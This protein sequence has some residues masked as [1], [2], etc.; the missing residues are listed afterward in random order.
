MILRVVENNGE[1]EIIKHCSLDD[2]VKLLLQHGKLVVLDDFK[3]NGCIKLLH[4]LCGALNKCGISVLY[5]SRKQHKLI[6][7]LHGCARKPC[8]KI[9][10]K[11]VL[12]R[13]RRKWNGFHISLLWLNG[14]LSLLHAMSLYYV[15]W[16]GMNPHH[17]HLMLGKSKHLLKMWFNIVPEWWRVKK[18]VKKARVITFH[19]TPH[20]LMMLR[21]LAEEKR[22]TVS[23]L[24]RQ[25]IQQLLERYR[26]N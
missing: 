17:T 20:Q 3:G 5:I 10:V 19:I 4:G 22:T 15:Y 14:A 2:A 1:V 13:L 11:R 26:N 6:F 18:T 9:L 7:T 23:E 16:L 8:R 12:R 25:A 21:K 24:I